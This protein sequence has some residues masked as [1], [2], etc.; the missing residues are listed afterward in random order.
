MTSSGEPPSTTTTEQLR[1]DA[2]KAPEGKDSARAIHSGSNS[3][4]TVT[5]VDRKE[6]DVIRPWGGVTHAH[7]A[8]LIEI[9]E[10]EADRFWV[11]VEAPAGELL[12]ERL[13][14]IGKKHPVD[15]V[16]TALRVADA[17]ATLHDAGGAHGRLHPDTV[18]LKPESGP[19]PL[20]LFGA[21]GPREYWPPDY[22]VAEPPS[23]LTDTWATGALL[24]HMLTGATPPSMGIGSAEELISLGIDNAPAKRGGRACP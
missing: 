5:G 9:I 2:G 21:P 10:V 24:F 13:R 14:S 18:L 1:F 7:L 12:S 16:R 19:E 3:S 8:K 15:A 4:V 6:V 17:L 22:S 23:V 11:V 20:V